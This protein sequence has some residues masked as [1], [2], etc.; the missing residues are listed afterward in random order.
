MTPICLSPWVLRTPQTNLIMAFVIQTRRGDSK[1]MY[2]TP[3]NKYPM[4]GI[5]YTNSKVFIFDKF[6]EYLK[7]SS[8][9]ELNLLPM[10]FK[11]TN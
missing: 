9:A 6:S 7:I 5:I 8:P 2:Y 3:N 11:K 1:Y 10:T 4:W